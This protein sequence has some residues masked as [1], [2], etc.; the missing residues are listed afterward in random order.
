MEAG[1]ALAVS[2][3][4]SVSGMG[5]VG[6]SVAGSGSEVAS[7]DCVGIIGLMSVGDAGAL[8]GGFVVGGVTAVWA[9]GSSLLLLLGMLKFSPLSWADAPK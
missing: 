5:C 7:G 3:G 1:R 6:G 8:G 2:V 9:T 4:M